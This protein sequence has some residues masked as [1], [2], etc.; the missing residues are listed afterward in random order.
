MLHFLLHSFPTRRSSDLLV[1][2]GEFDG[3]A[4]DQG[5]Q[6]IVAALEKRDAGRPRTQ[7]RLHDWGISRQR[8]WGCPIPIIHCDDCGDVPVPEEDLP[9]VLPENL[10]PDGSGNPLE[11]EI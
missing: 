11:T 4:R 3:L 5:A 9:V 1:N 6:A 7:F 8:Y 10:V 2:S